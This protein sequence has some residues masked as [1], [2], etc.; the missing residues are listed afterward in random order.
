MPKQ[1]LARHQF[2]VMGASEDQWLNSDSCRRSKLFHESVDLEHSKCEP[3][4]VKRAML[5]TLRATVRPGL[6]IL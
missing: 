4:D 5:T 1:A 3:R 6:C 2:Q